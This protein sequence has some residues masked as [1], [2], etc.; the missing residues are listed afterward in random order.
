MPSRHVISFIKGSIM[1]CRK[2]ESHERMTS[3]QIYEAHKSFYDEKAKEYI[4]EHLKNIGDVC[5]FPF[6]MKT[7]HT[8]GLIRRVAD[9][10]YQIFGGYVEFIHE[11]ENYKMTYSGET[12]SHQSNRVLDWY[13]TVYQCGFAFSNVPYWRENALKQSTDR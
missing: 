9:F 7:Y 3:G 5:Y 1:A 6:T 11:D 13:S 8:R 12:V 2:Y 4:M 10:E